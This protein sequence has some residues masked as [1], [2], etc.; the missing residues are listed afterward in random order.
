MADVAKL[1][2]DYITAFYSGDHERARALVASDFSFSG[3][4]VEAEG[5]DAFFSAAAPLSRIARG[6]EMMRQWQDG[7]DICSL[8]EVK[9]QTHAGAGSVLMCEWHTSRKALLVSGRV[10][11]DTAAFRALVPAR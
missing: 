9:L 11:F 4:F 3:P 10:V 1:A 8:F 6:H 2:T 5:A 7:D